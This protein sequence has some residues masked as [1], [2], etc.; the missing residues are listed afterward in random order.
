MHKMEES[1]ML[2]RKIMEEL[3]KWKVRP[4]KMCLIVKGARQVGK[5][6]II[7]STFPAPKHALNL[8]KSI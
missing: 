7:D 3:L 8:E 2:R 1:R 4:D 5:T 6:Y